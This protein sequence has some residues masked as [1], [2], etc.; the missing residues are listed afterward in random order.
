MRR[1]KSASEAESVSSAASSPGAKGDDK[2]MHGQSSTA[3]TASANSNSKTTGETPYLSI[4]ANIA[5]VMCMNG[6]M[7]SQLAMAF[8][9]EESTID[10]WKRI[11]KEFGDACKRGN[12]FADFTVERS[13][14]E[15]AVGYEY[16]DVKIFRYKGQVIYAPFMVHVP[17]NV[18][19]AIFWLTKYRS[20]ALNP[21][22][23]SNPD[24][25]SNEAMERLYK[26][27]MSRP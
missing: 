6:A 17:A 19:A 26:W 3:G 10:E 5:K 27:V 23:K 25:D 22:V 1:S 14:Y 4:F 12:D 8:Q 21:D 20:D 7:R 15:L 13:L 24:T 9:V 11:H 16:K 18:E 2:A